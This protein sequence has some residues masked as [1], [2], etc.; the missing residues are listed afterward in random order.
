M[1]NSRLSP[2][3]EPP[4]TRTQNQASLYFM[5]IVC[6]AYVPCSK[7]VIGPWHSQPRQ[8][9]PVGRSAAKLG[10]NEAQHS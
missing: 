2:H 9:Q 5:A 10:S 7:R 8:A 3:P 1:P 4:K 6:C